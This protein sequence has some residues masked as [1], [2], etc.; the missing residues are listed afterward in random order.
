MS[1]PSGT[2]IGPY[3]I[4]ELIGVGGMGEVYVATDTKLKREVAIKVLPAALASDPHRLARLQREAELL[5]TLN[6][7]NIA[8]IYG[9]E[10]FRSGAVADP[11]TMALVMELV[12]GPTL[13]DRII[14]GPI[15][16]AEALAIARQIAE[17]LEAAHERGIIHR[18]LKPANIKI[19]PDGTVKVLDFGLARV[20]ESDERGSTS[21]TQPPALTEIGIILG[22]AAYMSPEQAKG[23]PS[24][25]RSD[26]WAFGCVLYEMLTG[27]QTFGR[28][29]F[30][31][32]LAAVLREEPDWSALP[33][34][35]PAA[36]R[37]LLRRLVARERRARLADIADA[38]MELEE[39]TWEEPAS[40]LPSRR[41][42]HAWAIA[43]AA[44]LLATI[45]LT[46]WA[47]TRQAPGGSPSVRFDVLPPEGVTGIGSVGLAPNGRLLAFVA[48]SSGGRA[49]LWIR[50]LDSVAAQMV[51]GTEGMDPDFFWS[52]DSREIGFVAD[53]SLKAVSPDGGSPRILTTLPT[54]ARYTGTWGAN[55]DILLGEMSQALT[56]SF[57]A[58]GETAI[59][60]GILRVSD[61]GG[62]PALASEPASEQEQFHTLPHFLPDGRHYLFLAS[63]R[64]S[65]SYV[66]SLDSSART[67]LP[68]IASAAVY[69][70][71][72]HVI[73]VRDGALMAQ[74]FDPDR[75]ELG[76]RPVV[77]VDNFVRPG[78]R[79]GSFSVSA[80]GALAYSLAGAREQSRLVWFDRTGTELGVAASSAVYVNPELSKDDRYVAWDDGPF[81]ISDTWVLDLERGLTTRFTS[82]PGP[83][84][85][86]Q[87]SP[88]GRMIAFRSDR[89][90]PGR[91]YQRGFGVVSDPA[92]LPTGDEPGTPSDWSLDGRH[93]AY[94]L[95]N[96][97]WLL[98]LADRTRVRVTETPFVE[99]DARISPDGRWIA[100]H[101]NEG[102]SGR[103]NDVY[104]HSL[105]G[106]ATKVQVSS[107]GGIVPRWRRDGKE[108]YYLTPD[109][110]LM[111][112]PVDIEGDAPA[113]GVPS[114]LFQT[115]V[116]RV[117]LRAYTVSSDGRFLVNTLVDD[118]ARTPIRVALNWF[119]ELDRLTTN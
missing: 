119:E 6:H 71:S 43:A 106:S 29:D 92:L 60:G 91:I 36:I 3:E 110:M 2:R 66:G 19:R 94:V 15:P 25:K 58:I 45:G 53:G 107:M 115:H 73:F 55:G 4:S 34:E 72:G 80:S 37:R 26:I 111:A 98:Q 1:L 61:A 74:P 9:V 101:S 70:A 41:R 78:L 63:G 81:S 93:L 113:I 48:T 114:P 56:L 14:H 44:L 7:A 87:W 33:A 13:A 21:R 42:E 116:S 97:I 108:L 31:D 76:G 64:E 24:D 82:A 23:R 20:H 88:D 47:L 40:A 49:A 77:I 30:S 46:L 52:P 62:Q 100:Y 112:V 86:P 105:S 69:A 85:I 35:T 59:V 8:S 109:R 68:G 11:P 10:D 95:S 18:D 117:A 32:T 22:T 67:P 99:S 54:G 118:A 96:D 39:A 51:Q 65:G 38:R 104:I 102:G 79:T 90:Q 89:D 5:A 27:K 103:P 17:A 83:D 75:L 28:D 84:G 12:E 16:L 57:P 50:P